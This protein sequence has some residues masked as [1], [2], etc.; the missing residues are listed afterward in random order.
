MKIRRMII[1]AVAMFA[2]L[3]TAVAVSADAD[4]S[5]VTTEQTDKDKKQDTSTG[6][7]NVTGGVVSLSR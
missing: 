2:P 1:F 6:S 5:T 4:T 3:G 7:K